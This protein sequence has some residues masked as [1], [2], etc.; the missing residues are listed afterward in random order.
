MTKRWGFLAAFL[1]TV[2]VLSLPS[3]SGAVICDLT[4][5][6]S[7]CTVNGAIYKQVDPQPT[8]SGF[9][10]SF[11]RTDTPGGAL[12]V[13]EGYNTSLR[14]TAGQFNTTTPPN[15]NQYTNTSP[16]FTHDLNLSNVAIVNGYRVF[17]LDINESNSTVIDARLTLDKVQ[18][19]VLSALPAT[20]TYNRTLGTLNGVAPIY[21]LDAGGDNWVQLNY[22]LNSGSGSGDMLLFVP[23]ALFPTSGFVYLYS[24]FGCS[25]ETSANAC[26]AIGGTKYSQSDGYEE[27]ATI[28]AQAV[29][30]PATI[31]LL[32]IGLVGT[33]LMWSPRRQS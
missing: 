9:I 16:T 25:P 7:E 6:F 23:N 18:I 26:A 14:G 32:G 13:E 12:I 4:T 31:L 1:V 22:A 5:R 19:F 11:V 17:S 15:V 27:W 28:Q 33:G 2:L 24:L 21:N 20:T 29:P 3:P 30:E 10:D 8:G